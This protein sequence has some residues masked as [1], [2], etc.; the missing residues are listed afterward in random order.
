[1]TGT[2]DGK[3]SSSVD[4]PGSDLDGELS[5]SIGPQTTEVEVLGKI[6]VQSDLGPILR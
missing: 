3:M 4:L 2:V 6:P 1:M 5:G